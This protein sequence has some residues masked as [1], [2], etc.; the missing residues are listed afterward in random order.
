MFVIQRHLI[1]IYND[2]PSF[3]RV[4]ML[5]SMSSIIIY[6]LVVRKPEIAA[7]IINWKKRQIDFRIF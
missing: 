5:K 7:A 2:K 1:S 6:I 3:K 4:Q